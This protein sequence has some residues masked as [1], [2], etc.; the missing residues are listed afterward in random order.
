VIDQLVGCTL[1]TKFNIHWGYNNIRIKPGDEWKAAFLTPE[2]LFKPTVMFF[3]LTNSPVMFQMMMNM[4]FQCEVQE[5]WFLIFMDNRII[6]TKRQPREMED[7]H[8]QRHRDLVHRIFNILEKNNLYVKPE[9]C[10]FKQEEMEY[11][12]IIVGKGKM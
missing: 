9:K 11:L 8:R 6:Y 5:G 10:V 2:G 3:G 12:G 4:I 1:F 7:Q